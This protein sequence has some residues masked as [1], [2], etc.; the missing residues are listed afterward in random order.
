VATLLL[1]AG[2]PIEQVQ[3]LLRHKLVATTQIYAETNLRGMGENYVKAL[4]RRV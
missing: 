3:K 4:E 1:D 2:M